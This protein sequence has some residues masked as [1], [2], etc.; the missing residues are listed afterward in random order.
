M[1]RLKDKVAIVTGAGSGLGRE[2]AILYAQEGAR[3]VVAD[4]RDA[5]GVQVAA[6]IR[7]AGGEALFFKTDVS[8]SVEVRDLVAFTERRYGALH[9][10][11]ANAGI[12]GNASGRSFAE[13]SEEDF[14]HV[15]NVNFGGV[16]FSFKHA[17]P[18][19]LRSGGGAMT[20]TGSLAGHRA[21]GMLAAYGSSKAAIAGLVRS[22]ALDLFPRIRVNEIAPGGMATAMLARQEDERG[23]APAAASVRPQG[24]LI[25]DPRE[26]ARAHLYLVSDESA[27]V[28]GQTLFVDG[29]RSVVMAAMP[30]VSS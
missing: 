9:I 30:S 24:A 3:V 11:T 2:T 20:A 10:M 12:L 5:E 15:M 8:K 17:V 18:A 28:N 7:D 1:N 27:Y 21:T 22:L 26:V 6:A 16:Y 14:W 13:V 29:G 23:A 25:M 19:I 4:T